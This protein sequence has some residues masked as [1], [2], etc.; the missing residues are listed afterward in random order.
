[1]SIL[2][3]FENNQIKEISKDKLHPTFYAGDTLKI[4]LKIKEGEKR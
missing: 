1:M 3:D 4:H 2:K